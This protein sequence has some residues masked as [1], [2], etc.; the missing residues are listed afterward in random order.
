[1]GEVLVLLLIDKLSSDA[2]ASMGI[3]CGGADAQFPLQLCQPH[4]EFLCLSLC[5]SSCK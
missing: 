3:L 5:L 2:S 1:M 4:V